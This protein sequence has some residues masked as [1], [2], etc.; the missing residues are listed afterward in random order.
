MKNVFLLLFTSS[1]F[2]FSCEKQEEIT[3]IPDPIDLSVVTDPDVKFFVQNTDI[4]ILL[5]S[6]TLKFYGTDEQI[7][8]YVE[9]FAINKGTTVEQFINS[10][11]KYSPK[12]PILNILHNWSTR[13]RTYN[14]TLNGSTPIQNI[15]PLNYPNN[16]IVTNGIYLGLNTGKYNPLLV[17][18]E[19]EDKLFL[20]KKSFDGGEL[21]YLI[22]L[23][24]IKKNGTFTSPPVIK[25]YD[26]RMIKFSESPNYYYLYFYP[27]TGNIIDFTFDK[28]LLFYNNVDFKTLVDSFQNN[29]SGGNST[30]VCIVEYNKD[31]NGKIIWN[32][33][34]YIIS[35][36]LY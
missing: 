31:S 1:L 22:K 15:I 4:P 24:A 3:K 25:N 36:D 6:M 16:I 19:K 2:F 34:N 30:R 21:P 27:M 33:K 7:N 8:F 9:T 18:G 11:F 32:S 14:F 13:F 29:F 28:N 26:G 20:N 17:P 35:K 23:F 12:K 10:K 5:D